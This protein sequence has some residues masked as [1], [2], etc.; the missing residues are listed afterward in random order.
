MRKPWF[1]QCKIFLHIRF[2]CTIIYA[3]NT[4]L[5]ISKLIKFICTHVQ[6]QRFSKISLLLVLLT[7][8]LSLLCHRLSLN[9]GNRFFISSDVH[10]TINILLILSFLPIFQWDYITLFLVAFVIFIQFSTNLYLKYIA[11]L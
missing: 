2:Y 6:I 5:P 10:Q 9:F 4:A 1:Y 8:T 7:D 11:S 3:T